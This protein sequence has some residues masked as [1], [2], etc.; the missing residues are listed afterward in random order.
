VAAQR[1]KTAE[2]EIAN[3]REQLRP[4][5]ARH[6]GQQDRLVKLRD[7]HKKADELKIKIANAQRD[8]ELERAA[9][10][11]HYALPGNHDQL[12]LESQT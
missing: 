12:Y 4:Y 11:T 2:E 7:L 9:D 8:R 10:L 6:Q 1:K 5:Q 3:L